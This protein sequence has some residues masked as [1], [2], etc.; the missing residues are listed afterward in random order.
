MANRTVEVVFD[1]IPQTVEEFTSLPQASQTSEFDVAAL[2]VI[3]LSVYPKDKEQS[4]AML[5]VL[6]GP[7]PLSEMEKQFIR[8]RFMDSDY[9][10]R[11]FFKGAT[12]ENDYTVDAPYTIVVE[13]NP[14]SYEQEGYAKLFLKSGGADSLR[15]VQLRLAKDGKWYLWD[16]MLLG[17]IRQPESS[18]PWA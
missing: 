7:R 11:S 14:Y 13:D 4:L 3:A 9:V 8:D 6:R 17:G 5:N 12:P 18:N 2:T 15:N 1:R 16:Q 10:P